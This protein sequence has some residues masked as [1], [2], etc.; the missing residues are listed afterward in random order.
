MAENEWWLLY[1]AGKNTRLGQQPFQSP[2][3]FNFYRPGFIAPGTATGNAGLTA[4]ELQIVN[5]GAAIGYA[6]F[7]LDFVYNTTP[8]RNDTID[9]FVPDYTDEVALADKPEDLADHLN[10]LLLGGRM[11]PVTKDRIVTVLN[12]IPI[13]TDP[14]DAAADK[15]TRAS[16]AV[17][18]A[19]TS[20]T[21]ALEL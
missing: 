11:S 1:N 13:R 2:S 9:S 14:D 4:P 12:E 5:E 19:V 3:V 20:P 17:Y 21:F 7:M 18:M 16:L 8:T 6:N 15:I 10:A